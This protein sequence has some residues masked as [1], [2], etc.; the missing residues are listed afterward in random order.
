MFVW[1]GV[2]SPQ[3]SFYVPFMECLRPRTIGSLDRCA[4]WLE[5]LQK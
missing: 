4:G 5:K 1:T 3:R 2:A